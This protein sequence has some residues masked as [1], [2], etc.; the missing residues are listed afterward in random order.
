MSKKKHKKNKQLYTLIAMITF[1]IVLLVI[2]VLLVLGKNANEETATT[3]KNIPATSDTSNTQQNETSSST[4]ET[5]AA[6][7]DDYKNPM[8]KHEVHEGEWDLSTL[9]NTGVGFGY[10]EANRAEN[11]VP[12]DWAYYESKWG[13]YNVDW[14]QDINSNT[15]YLTMDVGF[16]NDSTEHIMEILKEK[17]VK[18]VFFITKMFYD[19]CSDIVA[20]MIEEGHIVG[21]HSCTHPDMPSLTIEQQ[22]AEIMDLYNAVKNDLGYEM[23]LFRFPEGRFSHQTLALAENLGFKSVFWS[24]AYNDYSSVQPEVTESYNKAVAHLH[25]GAI[26]LLHASSSTNEAFLA[27]FIDAARAQGYEFGKYPLS[28]N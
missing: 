4:E 14:I 17:N 13:M 12:T 3:E 6:E 25:P 21:N 8:S 10:S 23:K 24:Y 5:T 7:V 15:I 22:T 28:A 1:I 16:P 18:V 26:Y 9:D 11:M 2:L 20:K 27:D 19:E